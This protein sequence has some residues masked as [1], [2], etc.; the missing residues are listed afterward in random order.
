MSFNVPLVYD[1]R[2]VTSTI[3]GETISGFVEGSLISIDKADNI[4]TTT[5]GV[6]GRDL[7]LNINPMT[8]G[9]ATFSLQ[10]TSPFNKLM[11]KWAQVYQTGVPNG[12][13]AFFVPFEM[14]DPSGAY[15]S[16]VAWLETV[17]SLALAQETSEL[18]WVIHLQDAMPRT[19]ESWARV[20]GVAGLI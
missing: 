12:E 10:H 17:P 7:T 11:Y 18:T 9:T 14:K 6:D 2:K 13:Y 3:F 8:D 5:R 20:A 15:I 16:T 4:T 1:P 19:N